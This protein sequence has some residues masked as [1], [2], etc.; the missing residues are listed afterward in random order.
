MPY[1][2]ARHP[3][4]DAQPVPK[5][6]SGPPASPSRLHTGHDVLGR[7]RSLWLVQVSCPGGA[8][9]RL[10]AHLRAGRARE[11]ENSFT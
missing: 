11:S 4:A 9:V 2:I 3:L 7:A 5:Q 1:A 8:P 6:R 10:L